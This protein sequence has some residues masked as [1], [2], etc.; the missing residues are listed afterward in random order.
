[1]NREANL[2]LARPTTTMSGQ[3]F[4]SHSRQNRD[5]IQRLSE[6]LSRTNYEMYTEYFERMGRSNRGSIDQ[7]SEILADEIQRSAALLLLTP[8][9][10][11]RH[12]RSWI[13]WETGVAYQANRPIIVMEDVNTD[14]DLILPHINEYILFDCE[15]EEDLR[16]IRDFLDDLVRF[17]QGSNLPRRQQVTCYFPTEKEEGCG[18]QFGIWLQARAKSFKCPA[19]RRGE[20]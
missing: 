5:L 12:T 7:D 10:P 8:P 14:Y 4:V 11:Q 20:F 15:E 13:A 6:V 18:Q 1:M 19:C 2:V 9:N 16:D 3:I 17:Y